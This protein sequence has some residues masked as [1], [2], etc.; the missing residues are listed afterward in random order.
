MKRANSAL[1]H[2]RLYNCLDAFPGP[3][4]FDC[5]YTNPPWGASNQGESVCVFMQRGMEATSYGGEGLVVIADDDEL[6]W[7][8]RVLTRV[9][10]F[11]IDSGFFVQKMM[12][13][14]HLYHLDDAPNLRSCNLIF[15]ALPRHGSRAVSAAITD[16]K[17]LANFYGRGNAP[18]VRYVREKKRLEYG[19][20]HED[21]YSLEL[22]E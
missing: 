18:R 2:A 11:A 5:F 13:K 1:L 4:D 15:K 19:K 21:D 3:T 6:E 22:L 7:P 9:Q 17:R 20:A 14:M 16:P 8:K 12:P 10:Q